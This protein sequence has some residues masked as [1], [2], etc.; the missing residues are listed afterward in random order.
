MFLNHHHKNTASDLPCLGKRALLF[1]FQI[2]FP[3][4]TM[5]ES[6]R[7]MSTLVFSAPVALLPRIIKY[8][9]QF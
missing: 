5:N 6:E 3:L 2:T 1:L 7:A 4:D 8:F 9:H